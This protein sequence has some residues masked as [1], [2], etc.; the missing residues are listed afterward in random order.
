M[1]C[2]AL[3]LLSVSGFVCTLR[4]PD[5]LLLLLLPLLLLQLLLRETQANASRGGD[6]SWLCLPWRPGGGD[7]QWS[8]WRWETGSGSWVVEEGDTLTIYRPSVFLQT[9]RLQLFNNRATPARKLSSSQ[10]GTANMEIP[11]HRERKLNLPR[12]CTHP[13]AEPSECLY[14]NR[15]RKWL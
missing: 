1:F 11:T 9:L 2:P 6:R 7:S 14:S 13:I 15:Y 12:C 4:N 5:R 3:K 8:G 10:T